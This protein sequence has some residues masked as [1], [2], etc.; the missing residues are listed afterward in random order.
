[1]T[2]YQDYYHVLDVSYNVN[3]EELKLAY[4]QLAK[5]YH[6]DANAGDREKEEMF[7]LVSEAY[8]VL[9]DADKKAT[10]DLSLLLGLYEEEKVRSRKR[11]APTQPQYAYRPA[12]VTYSWK[13]YTGVTALVVVIVASIFAVPFGLSRYSSEYHYDKGLE[14]YQNEQ[15]YAALNSLERAIVD[16]GSKNVEACLLAGTILSEEYGQHKYAIEYMD[17]GLEFASSDGEKVQLLYNKGLYLK[18][19]ADYHAAIQQFTE[20][21]KYWPDYDSLYFAIA[22]T[23]AFNLDQYDVAIKY[24][25]ELEKEEKNFTEAAY[26]KAYCYY[27]LH[28]YS[29]AMQWV[30]NYIKKYGIDANAYVLRAK[31]KAKQGD[32]Q[33]ACEDIKKASRLH[34][35]EAENLTESYCM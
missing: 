8:E 34:S 27:K 17:R 24:F 31:V 3:P 12:A 2:N 22:S 16:F 30:D 28:N 20:A 26:G 29:D 14:Y 33:S 1:M 7:K 5:R 11:S 15:Y 9:S 21:L 19:S 13:T 35:G 4:R 6:P 25:S 10:Y 32:S 23:Y 18:G